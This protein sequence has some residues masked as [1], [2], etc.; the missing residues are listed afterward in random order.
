MKN[1]ESK[2]QLVESF[3][4]CPITGTRMQLDLYIKNWENLANWRRTENVTPKQAYFN[5]GNTAYSKAE[6]F[7]LKYKNKVVGIFLIRFRNDGFGIKAYKWGGNYDEWINYDT[8]KELDQI[9]ES[10]DRFN[11]M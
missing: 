3:I 7:V 9:R 10:L 11:D 2:W 8:S 5:T 6:S 1:Q 4:E